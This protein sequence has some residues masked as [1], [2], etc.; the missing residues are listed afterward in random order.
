MTRQEAWQILTTEPERRCEKSGQLTIFFQPDE[1]PDPDDFSSLK[2]FLDAW[3]EW[4]S[5]YPALAE[6]VE[7]IYSI[8]EY[9]IRLLNLDSLNTQFVELG[10]VSKSE[11]I[12]QFREYCSQTKLE[13]FSVD[14]VLQSHEC[15]VQ[16]FD[17]FYTVKN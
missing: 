7:A 5:Q 12:A 10:R 2:S 15:R 13:G 14:L 17:G 8:R 1:P 4:E 9:S 16:V 3:A 11:A 6:A